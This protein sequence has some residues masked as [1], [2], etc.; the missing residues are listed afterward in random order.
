V[1]SAEVELRFESGRW[2]ALG[3]GVDL[4]HSDLRGLDALLAAA[5]AVPGG[6]NRVHV[7]FDLDGLP[8]WLRQYHAHYCN[9]VLRVGAPR[10]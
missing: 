4:E 7:R 2:R 10:G 5:F 3:A 9:Y 8:S 6:P 1:T